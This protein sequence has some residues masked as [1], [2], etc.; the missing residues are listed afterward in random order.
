MAD[1]AT[2]DDERGVVDVVLAATA[3]EHVS[4]MQPLTMFIVVRKDLLKVGCTRS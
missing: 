3:K 4:A 2:H 1:D